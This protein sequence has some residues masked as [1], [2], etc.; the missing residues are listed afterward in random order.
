[1]LTTLWLVLATPQ[2]ASSLDAVEALP[3][4][5][6]LESG[7]TTVVVRGKL[8]RAA[9]RKA[10]DLAAAVYADVNA[11]FVQGEGPV[12]APVSLCLFETAEAYER[13]VL[14]VFGPEPH[15]ALGFYSPAERLVVA[16]LGH[17]YGN[18]RHELVHP[19][20]DDDF[21]RIP[22][23]L[24]EGLAALYG[25]ARLERGRFQFLVNYR[26][27]DL[28]AA[29]SDGTLPT[30]AALAHST[31]AELYGDRAMTWYAMGR[32]VLLYMAQRGDLESFVREV[33]IADPTPAHQ[34]AVLSRYV[35][36][37]AFIA[38]AERLP[39]R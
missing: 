37:A 38:W 18:L 19:L 39:A 27:R 15:S 8:S 5:A 28:R 4:V 12:S 21:P 2:V 20:L 25:T 31:R 7:P 6:R 14:Q 32:Y 33:H 24:N 29:L 26:V 30:L 13:F 11:R 36:D 17:S 9:A 10:R 35:S 1:M 23:W 16:N 22:A 34:L 3:I